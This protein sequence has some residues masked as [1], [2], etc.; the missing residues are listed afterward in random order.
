MWAA[1]LK[2]ETK[3]LSKDVKVLDKENIIVLIPV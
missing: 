3:Q 1:W 2:I